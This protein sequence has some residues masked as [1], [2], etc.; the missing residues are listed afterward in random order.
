MAVEDKKTKNPAAKDQPAVTP[1]KTAEAAPRADAGKAEA[2][3]AEAGKAEAGK[4]DAVKTE[5]GDP[6]PSNKG[7][8]EGQKPVSQA[9]KDNWNA[10]FAK[11]KKR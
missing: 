3:K 10:I 11:K 2:G 5:K 1:A 8:G 7:M 9:Y 4:A 6:T